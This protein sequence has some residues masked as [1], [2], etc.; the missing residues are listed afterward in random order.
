L[1]AKLFAQYGEDEIMS[2]IGRKPI[3]LGNVQVQVHDHT[4]TYKGKHT[5]GTHEL[6]DFIDAHVEGN[7][8]RLDVA[9]K[10]RD[11]DT[12]RFWGLH[13]ALLA[14]KIYGADV[15]FVKQLQINGLGFKAALVG[16]KVVFTLGYT[17]KIEISL[18]KEVS[19]E[20][21]KT[22]QL[23][24]FRSF[25]RMVL[26]EVCDQVRSLRVPEPYK[27]TGIKYSDEVIVR[28]AG[29]TKAA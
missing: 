20:I 25:D 16:S 14:N 29:K 17:H 4:V 21:D 6:P 7:R 19:L 8:L 13:R 22:G 5:A 2:K 3:A 18:P 24:T 15:G 10:L 9:E 26:G 11:R 12:S 23:L 27:G 28:K 1:A